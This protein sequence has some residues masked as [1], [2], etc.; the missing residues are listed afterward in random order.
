VVGAH[1]GEDQGVG[2]V[3]AA[4]EPGEAAWC[5]FAEDVVLA[6]V[7]LAGGVRARAGWGHDGDL[8]AAG[9][10]CAADHPPQAGPLVV[11]G[12]PLL[13]LV[14]VRGPFNDDQVSAV[15]V[16]VEQPGADPAEPF[17]AAQLGGGLEGGGPVG[18][19]EAGAGE[20]QVEAEYGGRGSTGSPQKAGWSGTT[21]RARISPGGACHAAGMGCPQMC[22]A[23]VGLRGWVCR[24]AVRSTSPSA[25]RA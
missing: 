25:S 14:A 20:A 23:T 18:A 11:A 16:L 9:V 21:Y 3:V 19:G 2:F 1:G 4:V 10:E 7:A 22:W 17:D 8:V 5:H 12:L 24:Q 13:A 15:E 6:G